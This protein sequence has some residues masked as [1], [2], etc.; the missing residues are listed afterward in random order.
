MAIERTL[1]I[2]KPDG[3]AQKVVGEV[4]RRLETN[5]F[6][7][8]GMKMLQLSQLQAQGFYIIHKERPFYKS[9]TTFMTEGSIVAIALEGENAIARWRDLMGPTDSTKA[10]KGTIRG[11]FG[12]SIERDIVHGSD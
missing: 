9:L 1:A 3:T 5:Q 11:D 7:I 2:I 8:L 12:A 10:P 4:I 6:R